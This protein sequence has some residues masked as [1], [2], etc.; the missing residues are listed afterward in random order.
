MKKFKIASFRPGVVGNGTAFEAQALIYKYLQKK[1]GWKFVIFKDEKDKFFDEELETITIPFKSRRTFPRTP[2]PRNLYLFNKH[3]VQQLKDF[4]FILSCDPTIYQQ[5]VHAAYVAKKWNIPLAF[6]A[7]LTIMG[8]GRSLSWKLQKPF[9]KWALQYSQIIWITVPKTAERFRDIGLSS[10]SI[11]SQFVVLGHPVDTEKFYPAEKRNS[12]STKTIIC[13]ARLVM[14]KGVHYIIQAAAPLIKNNKN[15]LLKIVGRGE[16]K[17]FLERLVKEEGIE[18]NVQ[19]IDPVPHSQL[20]DLYRQADIFIG[21]P[22]SISSWE[23]FFGVV[24]VEAMACGL[25]VITSRTGGIP[26]L[27]REKDVAIFVEE[28]DIIGIT[29]ALETLLYNQ[30]LY[31]Q[32]RINGR[33]YVQNYYSLPVIAEKYRKYIEEVLEMRGKK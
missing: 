22:V 13:V 16:A 29:T 6:D 23:E 21:H 31:E 33:E 9:A 11:S 2:I 8:E 7:S 12:N 25:P 28:R 14:E 4:D 15:I 5:G 1:Y 24:N 3:I 10:E 26:Y 20:P 27:I 32:L 30:D 19:F 18:E 17:S